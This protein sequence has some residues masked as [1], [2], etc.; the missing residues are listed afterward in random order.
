M[1]ILQFTFLIIFLA[2][3][4]GVGYWLLVT[5]DTYQGR[6]K[7]IGETLGWILIAFSVI[8]AIFSSFYS[9]MT[10]SKGYKYNACPLQKI[11]NPQARPVIDDEDD[12]DREDIQ[13]NE[14]RPSMNNNQ[15]TIQ[16]EE[17]PAKKDIK[18]HE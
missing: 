12:I 1:I 17:M 14:S 4:F 18:D 6:L 5:A 2:I 8:F 15:D 7:N 11:M 10:V 9:I 13:G 3:G 16:E